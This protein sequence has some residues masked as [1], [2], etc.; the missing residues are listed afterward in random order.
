MSIF[1]RIRA[2]FRRAQLAP[3]SEWFFVTFDENEVKI[4]AEPP[5]REP[6][7][8]GFTWDSI[9]RVCFKA[10]DLGVSDGI[11]VFTS[12]RPESYMIPI[13]ASGGSEF[14]SE[15]LRRQLFDA[16]L[17]I[18]AASSAGGLYCWPPHPPA[19]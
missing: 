17:A 19:S 14:W 9:V 6:W 15:V 4:R 11:Y 8:Q 7:S 1:E 18:E 5:R 3:L 10:E 16:Q 13:E 12:Q 2:F